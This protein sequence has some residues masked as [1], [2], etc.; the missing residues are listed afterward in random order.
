MQI[1]PELRLKLKALLLGGKFDY[2][3]PSPNR[4]VH[5]FC[6]GLPRS[7]THTLAYIFSRN[8]AAAHEP[9]TAA[10]IVNIL[11][12]F[13]QKYSKTTM[14]KILSCRDKILKLDIESSHYLHHIS[15]L[16]VEKFPQAKFIL[17]VREPMSWLES[18]V[19]QNYLTRNKGMWRALEEYRYSKYNYEHEFSNLK[20][21]R[22]IYPIR[23]YL[24]YWKDHI[25]TVLTN[26]PSERLLV[27]DTF[28]LSHEINNIA[29]FLGDE[30][31]TIDKD[32]QHS[33][34][35][36]KKI[37]LYDKLDQ[38]KIR[39]LVQIHCQDFIQKNLPFMNSYI[40]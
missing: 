29:S 23:S 26:V 4:S 11:D 27:I 40:I 22:N 5:V 19:N 16:L 35:M 34:K 20:D 33:G 6:V 24:S 14:L 12:W 10:T 1:G 9:N 3:F 31:I 30:G 32:K 7:G 17:T 2:L 36:P 28:K 18:E 38:N 8:Y 21:M 37:K 25:S 39:E 13:H 15:D